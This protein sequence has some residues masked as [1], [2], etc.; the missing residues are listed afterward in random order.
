MKVGVVEQA[1]AEFIAGTPLNTVNEIGLDRIYDRPLVGVARADD[2]LFTALKSADVVGPHHLSPGEWL[3]GAHTVL[4]YFLPFSKTVRVAN[5]QGDL[6]AVEWLYAR[7]EGEAVNN[8]LREFL[9]EWF[10]Q[11][12][13]QVVS[14]GLDTRLRVVD[15]RSNWSE[16][17]VA[18]I[19][20]LGTFSL[21]RSLITKAGAAGRLG[22]VIVSAEME[23]TERSYQAYDEYCSKCGVC[24]KRCPPRAIDENGK[25]NDICA[26]FLDST[27]ERYKPRYG[28]GKCQTAVP[29]EAAA[30][31]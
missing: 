20:G 5:R 7:I 13:S 28:C 29:C 14:P 4:S 6:P 27:L 1:V 9:V 16:R 8:A 26:K 2:A 31:V 3:A 22:S 10:Q 17:H 24:I 15:R 25:N 12:G 30:P 18:Y 23:P 19:A 21:N 11:A